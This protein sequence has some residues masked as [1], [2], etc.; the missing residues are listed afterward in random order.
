MRARK[1]PK[2]GEA[3]EKNA[4]VDGEAPVHASLRPVTSP[5]V[6]T[7]ERR[8]GDGSRSGRPRTALKLSF[9]EGPELREPQIVSFPG[10]PN[11]RE[12]EIVPLREGPDLR[13][14]GQSHSLKVRDFGGG[15]ELIPTGIRA[16][17]LRELHGRGVRGDQALRSRKAQRDAGG[18]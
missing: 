5:E 12:I 8:D 7:S 9:S 14:V 2:G 1:Q 15:D 3:F 10:G 11:L 4:S 13:E 6:A 18:R 17:E 16:S